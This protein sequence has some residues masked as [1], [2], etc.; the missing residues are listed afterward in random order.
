MEIVNLITKII[1]Q[2]V[3]IPNK[4]QTNKNWGSF[5]RGEF[6]AREPTGFSARCP[7]GGGHWIFQEFLIK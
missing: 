4:K 3:T 5:L 7:A 6:F 1:R 2:P